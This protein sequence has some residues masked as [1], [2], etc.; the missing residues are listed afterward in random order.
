MIAQSSAVSCIGRQGK[1]AGRPRATVGAGNR[2]DQPRLCVAAPAVATAQRVSDRPVPGTMV[3]MLARALAVL[4]AAA[5]AACDSDKVCWSFHSNPGG[6]QK[7]SPGGTVVVVQG[8]GGCGRTTSAVHVGGG[9]G[10]GAVRVWLP[11]D[12]DLAALERGDGVELRSPALGMQALWLPGAGLMAPE[13]G[14]AALRLS[15]PDA[16]R[17]HR[18]ASGPGTLHVAAGNVLVLESDAGL[19]V[20]GAG[21]EPEAVPA[22]VMLTTT[23]E[24]D[25][26]ALLFSDGTLRRLAAA[27]PPAPEQRLR[28]DPERDSLTL[29]GPRGEAQ[30]EFPGAAAVLHDG[31]DGLFLG[32]QLPGAA[33]LAVRGNRFLVRIEHR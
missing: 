8:N 22:S 17:V 5:L 28:H 1:R 12:T 31:A 13:S 6:T 18:A 33:L 21:P 15:L 26:L 7:G 23:P 29:L 19:L 25:G 11:F 27:P 3:R 14:P 4:A 30:A 24:G 20:L 2:H 32:A 16:A 10:R 9:D